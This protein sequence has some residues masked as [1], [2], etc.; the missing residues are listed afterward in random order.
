MS[1]TCYCSV[2]WCLNQNFILL[3]TVLRGHRYDL[4]QNMTQGL[5]ASES[6]G[7][8]RLLLKILT[9]GPP[10]TSVTSVSGSEMGNDHFH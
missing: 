6:L 10:S 9:L 1:K 8:G 4:S 5:P 7:R 2:W 3:G